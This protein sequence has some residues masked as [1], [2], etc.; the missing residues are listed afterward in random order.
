MAYMEYMEYENL[1][2]GLSFGLATNIKA[3]AAYSEMSEAERKQIIEEAQSVSS[4]ADMEALMD[5]I[6]RRE[7]W[8]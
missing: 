2:L 8:I 1:P 6:G 4:K 7:A 5:R 3:S